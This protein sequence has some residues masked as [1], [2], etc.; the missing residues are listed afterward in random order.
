M[1][2]IQCPQTNIQPPFDSGLVLSLPQVEETKM[3]ALP[4]FGQQ[5]LPAVALPRPDRSRSR[6]PEVLAEHNIPAGRCKAITYNVS[7]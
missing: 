1:K 5:G 3:T 7:S 6:A 4:G 2:E